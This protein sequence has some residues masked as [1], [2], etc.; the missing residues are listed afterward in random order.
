MDIESPNNVILKKPWFDMM[1]SMT[2]T[3][4]QL[5]RYPTLTGMTDIKEDQVATRILYIQSPEEVRL[6]IKDHQSNPE[7]SLPEKKKLSQI[8]IE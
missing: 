2:S 8:A 6:E 7:E 3:Y 1:K 5:V 4:H